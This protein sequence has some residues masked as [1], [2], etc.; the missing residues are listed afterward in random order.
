MNRSSR[1]TF[2][3]AALMGLAG[4]A[5]GPKA[6]TDQAYKAYWTCASQATRA[7]AGNRTLPTR[8]VAARA[9]AQCNP[10]YDAYRRAQVNLV[11]SKLASDNAG[12]A[13][14]LGEQQ[15]LIM[16][17]QVTASLTDYAGRLRD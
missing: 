3:L 12:L 1:W 8:Q 16:R 5:A 13:D 2:G 10:R 17:R 14:R 6:H 7:Y 15:A 9:Q 11:R 4:C